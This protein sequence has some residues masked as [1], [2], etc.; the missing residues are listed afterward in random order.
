[1]ARLS[2]QSYDRTKT[3]SMKRRKYLEV[4]REEEIAPR[5]AAS[6]WVLWTI[7]LDMFETWV[8]SEVFRSLDP[9]RIQAP[10]A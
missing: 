7:G 6:N 1:M 9:T 2:R 4:G 10:T 8:K 5:F 3:K